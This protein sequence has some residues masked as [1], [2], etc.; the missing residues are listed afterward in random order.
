[1]TQ[2]ID[3][4]RGPRRAEVDVV[5]QPVQGVVAG[6]LHGLHPAPAFLAQPQ[7]HAVGGQPLVGGVEVAGLQAGAHD[8]AALQGGFHRLQAA[9]GNAEL[10]LDFHAAMM[11][12]LFHRMQCR[13]LRRGGSNPPV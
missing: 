7:H 8:R 4:R 5:L 6:G 1:V 10:E 13:H 11:P 2:R 3:L 9:R 12:A